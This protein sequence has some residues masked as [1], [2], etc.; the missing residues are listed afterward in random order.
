[1]TLT[2]ISLLLL[3][4][5]FLCVQL[6][7]GGARPPA[8]FVAY[9]LVAFA[10]LATA[11][12]VRVPR[13]RPNPYCLGS[14]VLLAGYVIVRAWFSPVP[15]LA[16]PDLYAALA[17]L[18]CYLVC[19]LS[20]CETRH[21]LAIAL[22]LMVA[23]MA[24]VGV[25][26]AQL[27][28]QNFMLLPWV[29]RPDYGFRASG[30]FVTPAHLAAALGMLGGVAVSIACWSRVR[31]VLR[32]LAFYGFVVC[33]T[34][35][36]LTGSRSGYIATG[37]GLL[38]FAGLS[39]LLAQRFQRPN[40]FGLAMGAAV[41]LTAIVATAL[42]FIVHSEVFEKR[43]R[44]IQEVTGKAQLL[45][46]ITVMQRGQQPVFGTGSGTFL[47]YGRQYAG[48]ALQNDPQ[49]AHHEYRELLGEY[50]WTGA[51]LCGLFLA[52]HA[53]NAFV[54]LR[55]ILDRRLG[56]FT[57]VANSELAL[58]VGA[59][60]ALAIGAIQATREFI[61]H[62]PAILLLAAFLFAI[63]ANPT[64]ESRGSRRRGVL[65][66]GI[67][68]AAPAAALV[69]LI[70]IGVRFP[71]ALGAERARLALRD[72]DLKQAIARGLRAGASDPANAEAFYLAAEAARL[73]AVQTSDSARALELR[74]QAAGIYESA[75]RAFPGDVRL[76]LKLG[77]LRGDLGEFPAAAALFERAF[78]AA[79]HSGL[80]HAAIG[81]HWHRQKELARAR[82]AY[83]RAQ[84]LGETLYSGA[85]LED[86]EHD[87]AVARS[88]DAFA[89]LLPDPAPSRPAP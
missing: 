21:R 2:K 37:A 64:V 51:L 1:M 49:H 69:L 81:Y 55:R 72:G 52:A 83:Q 43:L 30:F 27:Q 79:P 8:A 80:V 73:L 57:P 35:V 31:L 12:L 26:I 45:A 46:P 70:A 74:R 68:Y 16:R 10:G 86:L 29:V 4:G 42:A 28:G 19:S 48:P 44:H 53:G 5:A 41:V 33:L 50:G 60:A 14:A 62:L 25:G 17:A 84:S 75:L 3:G 61:F 36:A 88:N 47:L 15:V 77:Q 39:A 82:A 32:G 89:D 71:S 20:L 76:L 67:A 56:P 13:V 63:L 23:A 85:G 65:P 66:W 7:L 22:L 6:L 38:L 59:V 87:E 34:G 54:G 24:H 58:I 9:A 11:G 18:V 78:A 40:F